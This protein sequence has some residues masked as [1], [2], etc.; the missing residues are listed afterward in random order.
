[1]END[2][3]TLKKVLGIVEWAIIG[4]ILFVL[5]FILVFASHKPSGNN[6]GS[7]FGYETRLVLSD[8][9]NASDDFYIGKDYKIK[10]FKAGD[11]V[12]I[13]DV[14]YEDSAKKDEFYVDLK[15]GDI[16]TYQSLTYHVV[17]T[18]RITNVEEV[19]TGD[20]VTDIKYTIQGDNVESTEYSSE[21]ISKNSGLIIGKVV[22][23]SAFIG[24]MYSSFLANKLLVYFVV[25]IPC[26]AGAVFETVKIVK[27]VREPKLEN[28]KQEQ[29]KLKEA[30]DQKDKEIEEL[31]KQLESLK[32]E[33]KKSSSSDNKTDV[34]G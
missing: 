27:I 8:S 31:K 1:M 26:V 10:S 21:V 18:H 3:K 9:M 2:K 30:Q 11:A 13:S 5:G 34:K 32:N 29:I 19:K 12:L 20:K 14:S 4:V 16:V 22:K 6:S 33:S 23:K 7:L 17:I 25:I 15:E 24:W 28:A